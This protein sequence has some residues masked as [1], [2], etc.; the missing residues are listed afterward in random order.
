MWPIS[1]MGFLVYPPNIILYFTY[2]FAWCQAAHQLLPFW[3]NL[4][5]NPHILIEWFSVK[6]RESFSSMYGN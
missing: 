4:S 5:D 6:L 3:F 1:N 2:P